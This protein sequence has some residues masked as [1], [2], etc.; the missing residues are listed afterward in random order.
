MSAATVLRC[1]A[2]EGIGCLQVARLGAI[3]LALVSLGC[4]PPAPP[5]QH[6]PPGGGSV[7][8]KGPG[9]GGLRVP[10]RPPPPQETDWEFA[11]ARVS[12]PQGFWSRGRPKV[13]VLLHG[14]TGPRDQVVDHLKYA[15]T[16][17]GFAMVRN[18]L[19]SPVGELYTFSD[20]RL[21]ASDW[22]DGANYVPNVPAL[23]KLPTKAVNDEQWPDHF[24]TP[25]AG[26]RSLCAMLTWRD[27]TRSI[28]DQARQA[29]DQVFRLYNRAF[30]SGDQPQILLVA[31]SMGG[32]VGRFILSDSFAGPDAKKLSFRA[33]FIRER[34]LCLTTLATPHE[35]SRLADSYRNVRN[36]VANEAN[37]GTIL[38]NAL[39]LQTPTQVLAGKLPYANDP[40]TLDLTTSAM[41]AH[42]SGDMALH[43]ACRADGTPVPIY[44]L[45]ARTPTGSH[46]NSV[47]ESATAIAAAD[48]RT[49][50]DLA[51]CLALD[52]ALVRQ[53]AG[54]WGPPPQGQQDLDIIQRWSV[55]SAI[56]SKVNMIKGGLD[57]FTRAVMDKFGGADAALTSALGG[58]M[59]LDP[60]LPIYIDKAH[61]IVVGSRPV[62]YPYWKFGNFKAAWD[63]CEA[64]DLTKPQTLPA[65]FQNVQRVLK[66]LGHNASELT[67]A[68]DPRNINRWE[69]HRAFDIP[70]LQIRTSDQPP[71][72]GEVDNDGLVSI[73]S[74]LAVH[75]G[76][77]HTQQCAYPGTGAGATRA[78]G[79]Y[80]L[81]RGPWDLCN[82]ASLITDISLATWLHA[83]IVDRAGPNPG[84]AEFSAWPTLMPHR[85]DTIRPGPI[86]RPPGQ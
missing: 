10:D 63:G 9:T 83:N 71:R 53:A 22:P 80:R 7:D 65:F 8:G 24:V 23:Q 57:P 62:T 54:G 21:A 47:S 86:R 69:K 45:G 28:A 11:D 58:A 32:L 18:L 43:R 41:R 20:V 14:Q 61:E 4:P 33:R 79:W 1:H 34:T 56:T 17:W 76:F 74:A 3:L 38:A 52:H 46:F 39:K 44:C 64:V 85:I 77:D 19:G 82:H 60:S 2:R 59:A 49:K 29:T 25:R 67:A 78:G 37:V 72:D 35:G 16:Q 84:A 27:G 13:V 70:C 26:D 68:L 15:R 6:P 5:P 51:V 75:L 42:N 12:V 30:S 66:N 81:R 48:L 73:D 40:A 36:V 55:R 50:T 31:H